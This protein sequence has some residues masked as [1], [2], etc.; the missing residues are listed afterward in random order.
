MT[1]IYNMSPNLLMPNIFFLYEEIYIAF[2]YLSSWEAYSERYQTSKVVRFAKIGT[3]K[4][5]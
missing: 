2:R 1:D 3:A 5:C 4:S